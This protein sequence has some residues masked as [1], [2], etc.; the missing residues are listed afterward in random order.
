M[1]LQDLKWDFNQEL[2]VKLISWRMWYVGNP[3]RG[4]RADGIDPVSGRMG[5]LAGTWA[6]I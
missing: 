5:R 6:D 2:G 4:R 3:E 1:I